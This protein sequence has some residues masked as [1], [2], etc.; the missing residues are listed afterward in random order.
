MRAIKVK[1]TNK[2]WFK[3]VMKFTLPS[4]NL[5]TLSIEY[6]NDVPQGISIKYYSREGRGQSETQVHLQKLE[7]KILSKKEWLAFFHN[8]KNRQRLFSLFVTYL[9]ADDFVQSRPLP[10]LVHNENE[11]LKTLLECNHEEVDTGKI[12]HV[13]Q[14]KSN[15]NSE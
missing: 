13:L 1:K 14:Q 4:S 9:C 5:K 2:E 7:E 10:I 15:V 11:T 6:V 3:A 12:F 8:I